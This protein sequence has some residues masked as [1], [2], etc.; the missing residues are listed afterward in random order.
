MNLE[1]LIAEVNYWGA[2]F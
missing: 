1:E 2:H